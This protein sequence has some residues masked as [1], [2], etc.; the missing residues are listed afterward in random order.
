MTF[1]IHVAEPIRTADLRKPGSDLKI[2]WR[3]GSSQSPLQIST[4]VNSGQDLRKSGC[5]SF[6]DMHNFARFL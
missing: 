4:F 3:H 2:G 5:Q 1:C 6:L